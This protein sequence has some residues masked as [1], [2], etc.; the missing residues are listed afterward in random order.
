M[1][2]HSHLYK[3]LKGTSLGDLVGESQLREHEKSKDYYVSIYLRENWGFLPS[4]LDHEDETLFSS[5]RH[6]MKKKMKAFHE[7]LDE[8]LRKRIYK[9]VVDKI[10]PVYK[11]Y[12]KKYGDLKYVNI[13]TEEDLVNMSEMVTDNHFPSTTSVT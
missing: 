9:L 4:L 6:V 11:S 2:N 3:A 7:V 8:S 5:E 12:I 1:N 10:V 13:Y